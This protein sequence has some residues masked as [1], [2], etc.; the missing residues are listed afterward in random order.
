MTNSAI[1]IGVVD[2]HN[3]FRRTVCDWLSDVN[4]IQVV[5][6][7]RGNKELVEK[8]PSCPY[9][10]VL[11][12]DLF[13]PGSDGKE[14]LRMLQTDYPLIK[15]IVLSMCHDPEIISGLL[16][17]GI[18]GCVTKGADTSELLEAI[19]RVAGG[20]LYQNKIL[21]EAMHWRKNA[22]KSG[23]LDISSRRFN[24]KQKKV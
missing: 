3:L 15:V 12:L 10:D 19:N 6:D 16:D 20:S 17:Y 22:F 7:A 23:S 13:M 11:L 8:L 24:D 21:T 18:F 5:M 14:I 2:D 9:I 4:G 1:R